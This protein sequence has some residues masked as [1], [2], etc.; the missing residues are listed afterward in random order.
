MRGHVV[1]RVRATAGE[2]L[3]LDPKCVEGLTAEPGQESP[4]GPGRA[5]ERAPRRAKGREGW[6]LATLIPM[7]LSNAQVLMLPCR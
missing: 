6:L 1:G 3:F 5:P 4:R 7:G 2:K